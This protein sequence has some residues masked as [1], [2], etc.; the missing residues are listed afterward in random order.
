MVEEGFYRFGVLHRED[1]PAVVHA[2]GTKE[3]WLE[4]E[5]LTHAEW[6]RRLGLPFRD[7]RSAPS[8]VAAAINRR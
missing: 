1:G 5:Q 4:G 2:D 8:S 7:L 6:R 3:W